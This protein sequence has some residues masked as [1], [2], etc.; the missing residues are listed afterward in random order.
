MHFIA[1][2]ATYRVTYLHTYHSRDENQQILLYLDGHGSRIN[3][4]AMKLF[5]Q[6]NIK[7]VT[8]R[9][10]TTHICQPFDR[11]IASPLKRYIKEYSSL[12]N[13][14]Y[15]QISNLTGT[16]LE[17]AKAVLCLYDAFEKSVDLANAESAF[18]ST[19][20]IPFNRNIVLANTNYVFNR[21]VPPNPPQPQH[22]RQQNIQNPVPGA[23]AL[24]IARRTNRYQIGEK[25]TTD[26]QTLRELL[27]HEFP[28]YPIPRILPHAVYPTIKH[29]LLINTVD[30]GKMLS[31][32]MRFLV[33]YQNGMM[34][35][36]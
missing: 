35:Y 1:W 25:V 20:L 8:L 21:P 22:V 18:R 19:G 7:V 36:I 6:N 33:R 23:A 10:H 32:F 28:G 24:H 31:Q 16:R 34:E 13:R 5:E 3:Y 2:T 15:P 17:R 29:R 14:R 12:W 11:V 30:K 27:Q 4:Q 9:P 26:W